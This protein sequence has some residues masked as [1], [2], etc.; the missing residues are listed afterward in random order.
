MDESPINDITPS[1]F[2]AFVAVLVL[3]RE[4]IQYFS[5]SVSHVLVHG[6]VDLIIAAVIFISLQIVN[7][8]KVKI[9]YKWVILLI[10]GAILLLITTL[11][12]FVFQYSEVL[13]LGPTL[14]LLAFLIEFLDQKKSYNASK[15]AVLVGSCIAIYESIMIF[16]TYSNIIV[17]NGIFGVIFAVGLILSMWD[18]ID[19]KIPLTWAVVLTAGFVIFT[20]ISPNYLGVA[21]TIILLGFLLM[22]RSD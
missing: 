3:I 18:K 22:L 16:L 21:G 19:I 2:V 4:A 5:S 14:V 11:L 6:V 8:R 20:W 9:P 7:L 13:Y 10:L 17:V 1:K 12:K 15:I